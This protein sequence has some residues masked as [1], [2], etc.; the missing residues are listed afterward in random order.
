MKNKRTLCEYTKK[1]S[2]KRKLLAVS[3]DHD[4][5]VIKL[6]VNYVRN[7]SLSL[8]VGDKTL[9]WSNSFEFSRNDNVPKTVSMPTPAR[10]VGP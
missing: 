1:K 2:D 10:K 9:E 8:T 5:E 6:D 3:I 4:S 7:S